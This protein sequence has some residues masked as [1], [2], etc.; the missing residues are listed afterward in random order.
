M[1]LSRESAAEKASKDVA[2]TK[3][4]S[5]DTTEE[6]ALV[7]RLDFRIFPVLMILCILNFIDRNNF[8]NARLK[9]LEKDLH[10]SDVQYQTCISILLVGYVL[11]E[12]PSNLILNYISQPSLYLRGCV[13][14]W[15][16]ISACTGA[17]N[18]APGAIMCRFFLG[19]IESSFFP[20]TLYYLSRWYTRRE[21]QLRV[22]LLNAGNL[23]A[24]A[25]GGL[26]AAGVLGNLQGRHGIAAWRWL[27]IIEGSITVAVALVAWPV[28]PN[29]PTSTTWLSARE[30]QI[31]QA[32]LMQD[33][34]IAD[35]DG[36][37]QGTLEGLKEAVIDPKVW[38]LA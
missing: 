17:T 36:L 11:F 12:L 35:E 15:G 4:L 1:E 33:A 29:Y 18:N 2:R 22:T 26:I 32:R 34:G 5:W 3:T 30:Q 14:V 24:Q 37:H 10:L 20:G 27:F 38:I 16:V 31:A 13:A 6:K 25:F 19:C 28:L 23:L 8:A 9:G 21:M 7:R